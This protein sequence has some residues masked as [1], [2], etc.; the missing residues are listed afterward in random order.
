MSASRI[1][2]TRSGHIEVRLP[3]LERAVVRSV[4][5][6]LR[7][8]VEGN[9]PAT[10]RLSPPAHDDPLREAEYRELVGSQLDEGR[11]RNIEIMEETA[12]ATRLEE[13]QALAWLAVANDLRLVLG[14]RLGITEETAE[15]EVAEDDPNAPALATFHYLGWLVSE[16]VDALGA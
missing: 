14:E 6:H 5:G 16:L 15:R 4:P 7:V 11:R 10:G 9:D 2:R 12:D 8:A 1:R 13:E 3:P